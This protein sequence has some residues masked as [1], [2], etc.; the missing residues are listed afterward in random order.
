MIPVYFII[1]PFVSRVAP[2]RLLLV[3]KIVSFENVF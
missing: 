3:D 1:V 2:A